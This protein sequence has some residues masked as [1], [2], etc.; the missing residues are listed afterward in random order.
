MAYTIEELLVKMRRVPS[1]ELEVNAISSTRRR[2]EHGLT[3][4]GLKIHCLS[5]DGREL[6]PLIE[7]LGGRQEVTEIHYYKHAMASLTLVLPPVGNAR[8]AIKLIEGIEAFC[9]SKLFNNPRIQIQVCSPCRLEPDLAAILTVAFYLGSDLL[10]RF[11]LDELATSFSTDNRYTD[12]KKHRG[13]RIVLYDGEGALDRDFE[14]WDL[15]GSTLQL[16]GALPFHNE[17]TDMLPCQTRVDIE[18]VNLVATL[19]S[20][21]QAIGWWEHLGHRFVD[22]VRA[23]LERHMLS[24]ILK[25]PWIHPGDGSK[26]DDA[27]Y[28]MALEEL[29]S[30]AF[31]EYARLQHRPPFWRR[32]QRPGILAEMRDLLRQYRAELIAE[33]QQ[34]MRERE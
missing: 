7:A 29:M 21:Y 12:H 27:S 19:L 8:T 28:F 17:R 20:H 2:V 16:L 10:R 22:D 4:V 15:Q 32:N 34:Q 14:W 30:Y 5:P 26:E 3:T 11:T 6:N 25:A 1:L 31:E 9:N 23:L 33:A 13:R 18:N 24:G